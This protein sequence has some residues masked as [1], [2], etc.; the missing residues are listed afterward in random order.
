MVW[1][2][3]GIKH[4]IYYGMVSIVVSDTLSV[5]VWYGI[6]YGIKHIV[7]HG[8]VYIMISGRISIMLWYLLWYQIIIIHH[9]TPFIMILDISIMVRNFVWC[10][11]L[12]IMVLY[13]LWYQ[14]HYLLWYGIY[15]GIYYGIS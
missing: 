2:F 5:M 7:Y 3:Y 4:I 15:C 12:F 6:Y 11:T 1:Y 10:Q 13:L 14:I 8:M 9:G